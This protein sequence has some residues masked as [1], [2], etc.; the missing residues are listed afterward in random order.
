MRWI[1]MENG[2]PAGFPTERPTSLEIP[3]VVDGDGIETQA[4]A[5]VGCGHWTDA[6]IMAAGWWPVVGA[7]DADFETETGYAVIEGQQQVAPMIEVR[8]IE[9]VRAFALRAIDAAAEAQRA[10]YITAGSGQAMTYMSKLEEARLQVDGAPGPFPIL[11]A[12]VGSDGA[13]VAEVANTVIATAEAWTAIAAQ[14]EGA[15][16]GAKREVQQ[17]AAVADVK[18]V[19]AAIA[20]PSP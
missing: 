18:A 12:C 11:A 5:V 2:V 7:A 10:K 3:A 15:R 9:T 8:P 14:I 17:A 1:K 19:L 13:T 16:L 4:A 20:W 6:E